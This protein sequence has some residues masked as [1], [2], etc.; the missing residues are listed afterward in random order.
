MT[1]PTLTAGGAALP[2]QIAERAAARFDEAG[3]MLLQNLFAPDRIGDIGRAY[4]QAYGH[5]PMSAAEPVAKPVGDGRLMIP[6]T[7]TGAFADSG[8]FA[9]PVAFAIISVL[10]GDDVVMGSCVAVTSRPGAADQPM[11]H[12]QGAL[13]G[14]PAIDDAAPPH[15]VTLVVP[16]VD[17]TENTGSTRFVVG[18]HRAPAC[19][20]AA[21]APDVAVGDAL[22][23]DSRICHGGMANLSQA[24]RPILYFTYHR[25]WYR[26]VSNFRTLPALHIDRRGLAGIS[27]EFRY[28]FQWAVRD[29][30]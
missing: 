14:E 23:F 24:P 29:P 20:D 17:M 5:I 7:M 3:V 25:A 18:S 4:D 26:D 13:F 9:P 10:L 8:L 12:D 27:A 22:L 11:H 1:I 21:I 28:L 15:S 6:L 19:Q 2:P 30:A 16:L